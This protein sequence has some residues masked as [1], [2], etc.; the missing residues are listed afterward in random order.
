MTDDPE[1]G[2]AEP[3][4][5]ATP[6]PEE[7]WERTVADMEAMADSR[8]ERD[9]WAAVSVAAER[10]VLDPP[11]GDLSD[12]FGLVFDVDPERA[13][14]VADAF[15]RCTFPR[16]E[17]YRNELG[18]TVFL[19]TEL[20][21]PGSELALLLAGRYRIEELDPVVRS[22]RAREELFTHLRTTDGHSLG[23]VRH[24][25]YE[26]FVPEGFTPDLDEER[27]L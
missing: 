19:V 13:D 16:Y 1:R 20:L 3:S 9:G 24:D 2:A 27:L 4:T 26:K 25:G 18:G 10:L 22:A 21:D 7:A 15:E 8:R 11:E 5:A 14:P 23:T 12:P 6:G 17:V